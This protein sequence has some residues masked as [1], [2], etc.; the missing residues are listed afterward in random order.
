M[1]YV[2]MRRDELGDEIRAEG[3][4]DLERVYE[5]PDFEE[6]DEAMEAALWAWEMAIEDR[7]NKIWSEIYGPEST[8]F[9]ER[10]YRDYFRTSFHQY[11][12]FV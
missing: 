10:E 3:H 11:G 5:F 4:P 9:L 7:V 12:P 2:V 1:K 8:L 6:G